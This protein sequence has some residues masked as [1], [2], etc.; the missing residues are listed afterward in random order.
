MEKGAENAR[1][2]AGRKGKV[3]AE[4]PLGKKNASEANPRRLT[5]LKT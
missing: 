1:V 3:L 4:N 2:T 5:L